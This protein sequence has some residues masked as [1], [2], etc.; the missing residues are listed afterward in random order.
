MIHRVVIF[1]GTFGQR[2]MG[3]VEGRAPKSP[4]VRTSIF[5]II[6]TA[7]RA[8]IATKGDGTAFVNRGRM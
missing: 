1:S 2:N 6:D 4:T 8:M 5:Q 3:S 7:V